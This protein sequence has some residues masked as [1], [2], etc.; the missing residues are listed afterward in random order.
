[1]QTGFDVIVLGA[2]PAGS[3]TSLRLARAGLRVA[4]LER[5][6]FDTSRIGESLPPAIQ[7]LLS[8]LSLWPDF[9]AI[10]PIPSFGT[11]SI[12]GSDTPDSHSHMVTP[13]G[14]GW[15]VDRLRFDFMLAEASVREG[16]ELRVNT[17]AAQFTGEGEGW[18]V[19]TIDETSGET[20]ELRARVI[21]DATGRS[22]WFSRRQH[23]ESIYFDSLVGIAA[24]VTRSGSGESCYTQVETITHGWWYSAPIAEDRFV[25][26]LMTDADQVKSN[27][28]NTNAGW[29][30]A[31][32]SAP[33]T[34]ER[35]QIDVDSSKIK[36]MELHLHSAISQ[37]LLRN[38]MR[39]SWIGVG[40]AALAVDPVSGSGVIRALRTARDASET[41]MDLLSGDRDAIPRYEKRR[42][43]E[44]TEYLVERAS[45]YAAE[46]RWAS[47]PFWKRRTSLLSNLGPE[48]E[49]GPKATV[50][51][52]PIL[53][54]VVDDESV[55]MSVRPKLAE[56][57][58]RPLRS[59]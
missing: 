25:A 36:T 39:A 24:Q 30:K 46:Q 17:R 52:R 32:C 19:Q 16:V 49:M 29:I 2:G 38:D 40:D 37:R 8:E 44:C 53:S 21:L 57:L 51:T 1:M 59:R 10:R 11:R 5:S 18:I 31:L 34:L 41:V 47:Y 4:L 33:S 20:A 42:N 15:H 12:W 55:A 58:D 28:L 54:A 9:K 6:R 48:M 22:A 13:Y 45:Y 7:P 56:L 23:C 43:V 35:L 3:A 27:G 14:Y 50:Q 26:V